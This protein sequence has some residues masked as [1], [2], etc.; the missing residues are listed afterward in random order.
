[1]NSQNSDNEVAPMHIP[2]D[3]ITMQGPTEDASISTEDV[4]EGPNTN[5]RRKAANRTLPWDLAAEELILVSPPPPPPAEDIP[6]TKKRRLEEPFSASK[7]EETAVS[8]PTDADQVDAELVKCTRATGHWTPE[9]DAKLYS[10]FTNTGT[11]KKKCGKEYKTDWGAITALVPGR[12][13][14]QCYDRWHNALDSSIDWAKG[15]TGK[16]SEDE[17]SKLK[18]AVQKH[19]GKDWGAIAALVPG[20]T[21]SQCNKRWRDVLNSGIA[22]TVG[23][24]GKW[25]EDE[26]SKL[27]DA[28]RTHDG[29]NWGLIAALVPGRTNVQCNKR[30]NNVLDPSIALPAGR[31]G[32]WTAVEDSKLKDAVQTIH[33]K[34]WNRISALVPGR[35][36]SQCR[37]RWKDVLDSSIDRASGRTGTWTDDEDTKLKDAAQA[38]GGKNWDA[39]AALVPGRTKVQC[40]NRWKDAFD[41]SMDR[42][43]RSTGKWSEDEDSKL[44][45]AVQTH[46][47][48]NWITIAALVP[49]RTRIQCR[50]KWHATLVSN[51][52]RASGRAGT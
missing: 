7:Y 31:T 12:T 23:R 24:V 16:W 36:K 48:K 32:K 27:Q 35:T 19:G 33:G 2:S 5:L 9:E 4:R 34:N 6:A 15:R 50:T 49:G 26:D 13:K 52:E 21:R 39:I 1:M 40:Y 20:R 45:D 29:K 37:C 47:D 3:T 8:L 14:N 51:I 43:N 17:D 42:T 46:G 25:A 41:P 28:V 11:C 22:L 30:W 38:H 18:D 10:A 44:K